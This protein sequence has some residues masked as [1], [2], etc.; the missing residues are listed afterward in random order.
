MLGRRLAADAFAFVILINTFES[1]GGKTTLLTKFAS[2]VLVPFTPGGR[3]CAS[4]AR[5]ARPSAAMIAGSSARVRVVHHPHPVEQV[6]ERPGEAA[7]SPR[8]PARRGCSGHDR[9]RRGAT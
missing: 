8:P 3:P 4:C 1:I 2:V 9:R 5:H 6:P 7:R